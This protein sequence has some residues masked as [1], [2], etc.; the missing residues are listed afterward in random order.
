MRHALFFCCVV[1]APVLL[2]SAGQSGEGDRPTRKG[3]ALTVTG[4]L[5]GTSLAATET[6]APDAAILLAGGLT[7]RLTGDKA[8]LRQLRARHDRRIVEVSGTLKSDL[9]RHDAQARTFGGMRIGI[10]APSPGVGRPEAESRRALPVLEVQE[11]E[12]GTTYCGR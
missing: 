7:F 6:S 4:C 11:F 9:P 2:G 12:G 10:G 8:L 1:M 5:S 3:D